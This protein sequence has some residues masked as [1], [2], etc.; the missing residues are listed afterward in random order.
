MN[1]ETCTSYKFTDE[2]F[3]PSS[4]ISNSTA[5]TTTTSTTTS[6]PC[7][8]E[9]FLYIIPTILIV[10]TRL[11]IAVHYVLWWLDRRYEHVKLL[12][13]VHQT[14][15]KR[16]KTSSL[17]L[18]D[19]FTPYSASATVLIALLDFVILL[20]TS[21]DIA[22]APRNYICI[23]LLGGLNL[24]WGLIWVLTCVKLIQA[25]VRVAAQEGG[26]AGTGGGGVQGGGGG[27]GG[28]GAQGG[29]II[30]DESSI[31]TILT[32]IQN[33]LL[34]PN[35]LRVVLCINILI[36]L[37][38]VCLAFVP[39][40]NIFFGLIGV[41]ILLFV[42]ILLAQLQKL[43]MVTMKFKKPDKIRNAHIFKLKRLIRIQQGV[44]A[45]I[46]LFAIILFE[47]FAFDIIP[48]DWKTCFAMMFVELTM[49]TFTSLSLPKSNKKHSTSSES[50]KKG[51]QGLA[52]YSPFRHISRVTNNS[53]HNI[54]DHNNNNNPTIHSGGGG[55][56]NNNAGTGGD[57]TAMG[58]TD[59]NNNNTI[60][61]NDYEQAQL[62]AQA[63]RAKLM[64]DPS[65]TS[66]QLN[67]VVYL[68]SPKDIKKKLKTQRKYGKQKNLK[69]V[70]DEGS[71][72]YDS[73][74]VSTRIEDVPT[75][76]TATTNNTSTTSSSITGG[77]NNNN[78]KK[79]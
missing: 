44:L 49:A 3:I 42:I 46:G 16:R 58:G 61:T 22:N 36:W 39:M 29:G 62:T 38:S 34:H 77:G 51:E 32:Q 30:G 57:G 4:T 11:G 21:L 20:L 75:L 41:Q 79:Q 1:I 67:S 9:I 54:T 64:R 31:I 27:G 40:I 68:D 76:N 37:G 66:L 25:G 47:L 48:I 45:S 5:T 7:Q 53:K 2:F 23:G 56:N 43:L 12:Q 28:G 74:R 60:S 70:E 78:N 63:Q 52:K 6:T 73:S 14:S 59:G 18:D 26:G 72:F 50:H 55:N 13:R 17:C 15:F 24:C 69:P 65:K 19:S 8:E 33:F 10:C 35:T 71:Q